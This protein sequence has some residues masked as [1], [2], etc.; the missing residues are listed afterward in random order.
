MAK[1]KVKTKP[2]ARKPSAA[3]KSTGYTIETGIAK[4]PVTSGGKTPERVALETM[5]VG[6]SF[7]FANQSVVKRVKDICYRLK[8]EA[9]RRYSVCK[10]DTGWRAF[11][12]A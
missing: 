1:R 12:D 4:P 8:Q 5:K 6:Q 10:T 2:A 11:R 7:A 3:P 9:G